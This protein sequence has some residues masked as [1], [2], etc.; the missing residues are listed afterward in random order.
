MAF[1]LRYNFDPWV[2]HAENRS[3]I[4]EKCLCL[5]DDQRWTM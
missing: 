4:M 1:H 5:I 2:Y 3:M